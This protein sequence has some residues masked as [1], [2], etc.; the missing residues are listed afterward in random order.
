MRA[1]RHDTG[2]NAVRLNSGMELLLVTL[3]GVRDTLVI[4]CNIYHIKRYNLTFH[5]SFVFYRSGKPHLTF[6]DLTRDTE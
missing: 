1:T 3:P 4:K 2:V 5:I 6:S